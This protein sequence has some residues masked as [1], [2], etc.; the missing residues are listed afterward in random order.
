[1]YG[2]CNGILLQVFLKHA[3]LMRPQRA[4]L[5]TTNA[6]F[7]C[8]SATATNSFRFTSRNVRFCHVVCLHAGVSRNR[9]P[10]PL[11][12]F[13]TSE[14][15]PRPVRVT[16]NTTIHLLFCLSFR[17]VPSTGHLLANASVGLYQSNDVTPTC[18]QARCYSRATGAKCN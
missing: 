5:T 13:L 12:T 10:F 9:L 16:R 7:A 2:F 18:A 17:Y 6:V 15:I 1:M 14:S 8:P 4:V 11:F 3:L